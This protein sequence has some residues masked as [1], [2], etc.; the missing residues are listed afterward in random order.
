M[1]RVNQYV[2]DITSKYSVVEKF[3]STNFDCFIKLVDKLKFM[4]G[5]SIIDGKLLQMHTD[6]VVV[7]CDFSNIMSNKG[8]LIFIIERDHLQY[9]K[10]IA[11]KSNDVFCLEADEEY[12]FTDG[13]G[14]QK[15]EKFYEQLAAYS[16]SPYLDAIERTKTKLSVNQTKTFNVFTK[17]ANTVDIWIYDNVLGCLL[18]DS[19]RAFTFRPE[20]IAEVS[21]KKPDNILRSF[22]FPLVQ[23]KK[24]ELSIMKDNNDIWLKQSV[25]VGSKMIINTYEKVISALSSFK[26]IPQSLVA[27]E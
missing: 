13:S 1:P 9:L 26:S 21:S 10:M 27:L 23:G 2:D 3:T 16:F 4:R 7:E 17:K 8:T 14:T 18:I 20:T 22:S 25:E 15:V 19:E 5:I 24:L 11:G 6:D 12:I